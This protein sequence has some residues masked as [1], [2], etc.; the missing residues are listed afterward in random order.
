MTIDVL[1][2]DV[3]A[4]EECL[5]VRIAIHVDVRVRVGVAREELLEPQRAG[6]VC[7]ADERRVAEAA[8][9]EH[10]AAQDE[11]PHE[12]ITDL[13]ILLNEPP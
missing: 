9:D 11:R 12:Q 1:H 3:K 4:I 13:G 7:R 6:R 8:R 5:H 2:A 10:H